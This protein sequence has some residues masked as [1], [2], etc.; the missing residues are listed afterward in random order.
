[1][2]SCLAEAAGGSGHRLGQ[3]CRCPIHEDP[4]PP[5]KTGVDHPEGL[6]RIGELNDG[7]GT[8]IRRLQ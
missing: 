3:G 1:M 2:T 7:D 4:L 8:G 6:A 5:M